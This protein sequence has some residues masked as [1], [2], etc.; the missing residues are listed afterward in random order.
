MRTF[1]QF[2][3]YSASVVLL[4]AR[5]RWSNTRWQYLNYMHYS[6]MRRWRCSKR[7][8]DSKGWT[9]RRATAPTSRCSCWRVS[10][11]TL[12]LKP[13]A[14]DGCHSVPWSQPIF[15]I[16]K[17]TA[18]SIRFRSFRAII[19]KPSRDTESDTSKCFLWPVSAAAVS[20]LYIHQIFASFHAALCMRYISPFWSCVHSARAIFAGAKSEYQVIV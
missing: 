14:L 3:H 11:A 19:C 15:S 9:S 4:R 7:R 20:L 8:R 17:W 16:P 1:S 18:Q 10:V 2:T 5:T 13:T 6:K 12:G